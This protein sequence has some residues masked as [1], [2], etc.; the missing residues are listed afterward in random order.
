[1]T[2]FFAAG[3][4]DLFGDRFPTEHTWFGLS[5]QVK[6]SLVGLLN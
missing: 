4:N 1:M 2:G 6:G 3:Q 5:H